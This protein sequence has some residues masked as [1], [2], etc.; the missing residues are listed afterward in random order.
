M[1]TGNVVLGLLAGV[2]AGAVLG[3]LFAPDKGST[4][5]R[6]ILH[7]GGDYADEVKEKFNDLLSSIT[8]QYETVKREAEELVTKGR[9]K[10]EEAKNN[11]KH[12]QATV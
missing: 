4:T 11:G 2:A 6:K 10:L 1:K 7:K 12:A 3:I 9:A 8:E 5:R